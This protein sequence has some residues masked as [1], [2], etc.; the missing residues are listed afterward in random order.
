MRYVLALGCLLACGCSHQSAVVGKW[1][2]ADNWTYN[3]NRDSTFT[4]DTGAKQSP[5]LKPQEA[6]KERLKEDGT[7]EFDGNSLT[8]HV[9]KITNGLDKP[10]KRLLTWQRYS[11]VPDGDV[12]TVALLASDFVSPQREAERKALAERGPDYE[13]WVRTPLGSH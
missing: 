11:F 2:T 6:E 3:F 1:A 12:A 10:L 5:F 7:Y 8:L 4:F 13:Y 9:N